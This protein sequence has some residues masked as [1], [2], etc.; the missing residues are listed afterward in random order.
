[1]SQGLSVYVILGLLCKTNCSGYDLKRKIAKTSEFY[2]S[3]SNAQIYPV[4]RRLEAQGLVTASLDAS[5]GARNKVIYAITPKGQLEL[6]QWLNKDCEVGLTR[7]EFLMQVSLGQFLDKVE[8]CHKIEHYGHSVQAKL[9]EVKRIISHL[10]E[11]HADKADQ[12]FLTLTYQHLESV[13]QAKLS[14]CDKA[15][16]ALAKLMLPVERHPQG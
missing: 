6:M 13:L 9:K 8:L 14:W 5:S 2:G 10:S 1:M 12:T 16:Q 7:E 15:R 3:E 4:L 11:A